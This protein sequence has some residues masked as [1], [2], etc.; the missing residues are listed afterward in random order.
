MLV[1]EAKWIREQLIN[2]FKKE[3][4]PILNLGSS[5]EEFRTKSQ[6]H[7]QNEIFSYLEKNNFKV[8]HCDIKKSNGIDIVGDINNKKFREK[9][10]KLNIKS[11]ICSN[12]L[13][14]V[15]NPLEICKSINE[16]LPKNGKL[17]LT[18]PYQFP[19]HKDP[20]DTMFRPTI[21]DLKVMFKE[22]DMISEKLVVSKNNFFKILKSNKKYFF[23][24]IL[25]WLIPFYKFSEWKLFV[26]DLF[27]MN[28][29]FSA[30]CV[31][32]FKF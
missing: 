22:F 10:K 25:R 28:K 2:S 29:N 4:F 14:H 24:M 15:S 13:E 16:I 19:F 23:L 1:E 5:T 26:K 20:I 7:I 17:I 3:D 9:I 18:T 30:S 6:K 11:V 31:L 27:E 32:L 12:L 8:I 21:N